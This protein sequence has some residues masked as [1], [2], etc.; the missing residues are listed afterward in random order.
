MMSIK[1]G[2]LVRALWV[3]WVACLRFLC[4]EQRPNPPDVNLLRPFCPLR[5][6]PACA[7][8]FLQVDDDEVMRLGGGVN[9]QIHVRHARS[10][11][12]GVFA[13]RSALRESRG[14][15]GRRQVAHDSKSRNA[16]GSLSPVLVTGRQH[17]FGY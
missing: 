7:V 12:D 15:W 17:G 10:I 13:H 1:S 6:W 11:L 2:R 5:R 8:A 3:S 9:Q 14:R 16:A 4:T